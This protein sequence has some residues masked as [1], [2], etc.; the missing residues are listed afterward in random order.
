L[1][2]SLFQ[3]RL[4]NCLASGAFAGVLIDEARRK[5]ERTNDEAKAQPPAKCV[6]E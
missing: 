6:K 2:R 4:S 1:S 3:K 5:L